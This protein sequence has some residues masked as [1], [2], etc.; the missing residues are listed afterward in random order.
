MIDSVIELNSERDIMNAQLESL[1]E[2]RDK[3]NEQML[4]VE[5]K[6]VSLVSD[7][8]ELKNQLHL[9]N[10]KAEKQKGKF[11]GLQVVLE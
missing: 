6:I 5:D 4:K 3:M 11:S 1:N 10:E 9:I 7:K 2:N 8:I